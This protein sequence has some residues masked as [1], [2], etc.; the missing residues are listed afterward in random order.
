MKYNNVKYNELREKY[1]E[2]N[3]DNYSYVF[4]DNKLEIT[5][6]FSQYDGINFKPKWTIPISEDEYI[7]KDRSFLDKII[8]NLGL[9]EVIS[10]WKATCSPILNVKCSTLNEHQK[11]WWKKLYF[12]GLGEFFYTNHISVNESDF[13]DII[14]KDELEQ[15]KIILKDDFEGCLIPIGGGKDSIVTLE[16]LNKSKQKLDNLCYIVNPRGATIEAA[17]ISGYIDKTV[18]VNRTIDKKLLD[19]NNN[20]FLNGHTPF[21]AILA[22]SSYLT[23]YLYNKKFITLSNE[24]SANESNVEGTNV[25]HQYSKSI[26]FENDFRE[27]AQIYLSDKIQYFSLL[28]PLNEFKIVQIFCQYNKYFKV[29]KSCNVGSK[30]DI[31]CNN[32]P[33]CLYVYIMLSAFLSSEEINVIFETNMFDNIELANI[34]DGLVSSK[35]DKP[36]E[37][38]GTKEE[39]NYALYI[40]I[41]KLKEN[42]KELPPLLSYYMNNYSDIYDN[43]LRNNVKNNVENYY[44]LEN[45][46]PI[47]FKGLI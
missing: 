38:V 39:I 19:L 22:F 37:C 3:Y 36:F 2:F 12:N 43:I 44:D 11:K 17:K 8:F 40:K 23:A 9:V 45:N 47:E 14:C 1:K 20:G 33:K 5:F 25:N 42:K 13:I 32:C 27:Y 10:Y 15:N 18:S 16:T 24:S 29:F 30:E 4:V 34:L 35:F 7:K 21:S 41:N 31:W 28:R 6:E 46:I 26:E